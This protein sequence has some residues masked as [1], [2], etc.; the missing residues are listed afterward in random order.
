MA[1]ITVHVP[2]KCLYA[3]YI[4]TI[5]VSLITLTE[6]QNATGRKTKWFV[7]LTEKLNSCNKEVSDR[8]QILRLVMYSKKSGSVSFVARLPTFQID[9]GLGTWD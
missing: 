7:K 1:K 8:K 4:Y 6:Q 5:I 2:S 9:L 3:F